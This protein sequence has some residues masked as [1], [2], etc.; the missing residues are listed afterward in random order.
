METDLSE[1]GALALERR[2]IRW[3][4]R[5]DLGTGILRNRTDGGEGVTGRVMTPE[6][7]DKISKISKAMWQDPEYRAKI[8]KGVSKASK[9]MWQDPE[10]RDKISKSVTKA[11]SKTWIVTNPCG[12]S[13]TITNLAQFCRDNGLHQGTM[14]DLASG[15]WQTHKGWRCQRA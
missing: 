13:M 1:I 10:Y 12:E 4:G 15:K 7:R 11:K 8:S 2:Y 6:Y 3:Y 9:A 14:V 5:K